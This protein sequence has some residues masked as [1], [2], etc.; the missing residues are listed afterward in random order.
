MHW[1]LGCSRV[2]GSQGYRFGFRFLECRDVG[3]VQ[4]GSTKR[5]SLGLCGL[6]VYGLGLQLGLLDDLQAATV[7]ITNPHNG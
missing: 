5:L 3:Y 6:R 4:A 7:Q 2:L 1:T